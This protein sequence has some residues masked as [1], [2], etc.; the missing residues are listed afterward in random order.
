MLL[1][2]IS[3]SIQHNL[4]FINFKFQD[5][6]SPKV[7]TQKFF[8][9]W[10][11]LNYKELLYAIFTGPFPLLNDL[12]FKLQLKGFC[13]IFG[14]V[15][16]FTNIKPPYC[17]FVIFSLYLSLSISLSFFLSSFCAKICP[18]GFSSLSLFLW[19]HIY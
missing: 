5:F 14:A 16:V 17:V 7:L 9:I 15:L 19:P 18:M 10:S 13:F 3:T 4:L 6:K 12:N 8:L 2:P 11:I 1:K